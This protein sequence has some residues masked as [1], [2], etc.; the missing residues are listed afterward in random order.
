MSTSVWKASSPPMRATQKTYFA[1]GEGGPAVG[2]GGDGR[3]DAVVLE[4]ALAELAHHLQV[5][6]VDVGEGD[7]HAAQLGHRHE[8]TEQ[9]AGEADG[10][11]SDE[12]DLERHPGSRGLVAGSCCTVGAVRSRVG[13]PC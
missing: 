2:G 13:V 7:L 12:G 11:G 10:T 3:G 1:S 5:A 4:V 9:R 6:L 8:V